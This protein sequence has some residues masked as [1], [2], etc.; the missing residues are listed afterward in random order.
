MTG[1]RA[2]LVATGLL[3]SACSATVAPQIPPASPTATASADAIATRIPPGVGAVEMKPRLLL[4]VPYAP[5]LDALGGSTARVG[6][7]SASGATSL[8]VDERERIYLWDQNRLRIAV[9]EAGTFA[10]TIPVP[11]VER[12]SR[13]LVVEGDR[14]YLRSSGGL[15]YEIDAASGSL[16]RAGRSSASIYP[17]LRTADPQ[18]LASQSLV[19]GLGFGYGYEADPP[20]Q[21]YVRK[22]STG[23]A[24]AYA[25]E[26]LALKGVDAYARRDGALYE[27]ASD[28]GGVGSAYVYALLPAAGSAPASNT[29]AATV[30]PTAFDRPVPD[31]L[32]AT[33]SDAGSIDLDPPARTA[34][35]WLASTGEERSNMSLLPGGPVFV[36]RW[37]DGSSLEISVDGAVLGVADKRS[38]TATR[39]Y[40][41]LAVAALAAPARLMAL[42]V[43]DGATIRMPDVAEAE[44]RLIAPELDLLRSALANAFSVSE[45]ELP[46][47]LEE[48]FP[49]YDLAI[50]DTTVR[51]HGDRH[52]SVGR[53]GAF[54]H[55]GSLATLLRR[56][57]PV[58]VFSMDDPRSLFLAD[59]VMFEQ[60]G[61]P[62][63]SQDISRWKAT[64]VRTLTGRASLQPDPPNEPAA[65]LTFFFS[66]GR[67]DSVRVTTGTY[68]YRGTRHIRPGALGL[69]YLRGVP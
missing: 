57:L 67:T 12:D 43:R 24:V 53:L 41:Q 13:A 18:R 23:R 1:V 22:D 44:H 58:P 5:R 60:D 56:L 20:A 52:G 33:L 61:L 36:A 65:T 17:R 32:T 34:F 69:V 62:S 29:P 16:L 21:K 14:L 3:A 9:F 64:I 4:T 19:D 38:L 49:R 45:S 39:A 51:L 63:A 8:A 59:R 30:A 27:L 6:G 26:P 40:E 50:G 35:W 7:L 42:A 2:L 47:V 66:G 28:F 37:N 54:A 25:V 68:T 55:D 10:R 31:R 48:P 46:G 15:E 11:Y